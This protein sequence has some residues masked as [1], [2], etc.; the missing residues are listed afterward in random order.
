MN[1]GAL[2]PFARRFDVFERDH[3]EV[4]YTSREQR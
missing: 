2:D 4:Q 1:N 3:G